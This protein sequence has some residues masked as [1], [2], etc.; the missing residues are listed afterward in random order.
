M[1]SATYRGLHASLPG[2]ADAELRRRKAEV[3]VE[4]GHQHG[5]RRGSTFFSSS[6]QGKNELEL[7]KRTD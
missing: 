5:L 2:K 7:R 3:R 1:S 6:K 4:V